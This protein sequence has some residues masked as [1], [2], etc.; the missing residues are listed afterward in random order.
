MLQATARLSIINLHIDLEN[1]GNDK[2]NAAKQVAIIMGRQS[3]WETMRNAAETLEKLGITYESLIISA[4]RTPDR[5]VD[6]AKSARSFC[7]PV[8]YS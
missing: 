1:P 6:F 2:M 5:L 3:D 8:K 7:Q 4:H